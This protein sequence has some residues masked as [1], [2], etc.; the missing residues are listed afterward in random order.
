MSFNFSNSKSNR[1]IKKECGSIETSKAAFSKNLINTL[2]MADK[3]KKFFEKKKVEAKFKMAGPGHKLTESSK[4]PV[5]GASGRPA[6]S[7][8]INQRASPSAEAKQAAAA[9]LARL[10]G[11]KR[12]N[13]AFNT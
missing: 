8:S 10:G 13:P 4:K 1:R 12:E 7:T 9:A 2:K 5:Q 6:P 11:E 3:I